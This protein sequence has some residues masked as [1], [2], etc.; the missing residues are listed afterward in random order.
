MPSSSESRLEKKHR[1]ILREY[2]D[3]VRSFRQYLDK[4]VQNR[5]SKHEDPEHLLGQLHSSMLTCKSCSLYRARTNLVFGRGNP[6]AKIMLAGEAPG[7]DEDLEG[8]PFVGAAGKLLSQQLKR[9]EIREEEV[10][11]AN[12]LKCRPPGNRDPLPEEIEACLP[13]LKRQVEIIHPR[14]ICTLGKFA[15]QVL[16][17]TPKGITSL[18]GKPQRYGENITIIPTFHPAACIYNPA[19]RS[20][21][22]RDLELVKTKLAEQD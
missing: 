17:G 19:W 12:V 15:T 14:I 9:A 1:E 18:R 5:R 10:Y 16:L 6:N 4:R 11:I 2:L 13:Y 7:R 20:L 22:I 8:K 21:L 3:I